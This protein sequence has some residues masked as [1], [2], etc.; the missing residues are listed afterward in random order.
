M[1]LI[2][3]MTLIMVMLLVTSLQPR[4]FFVLKWVVSGGRWQAQ[5]RWQMMVCR[6]ISKS[7]VAQWTSL[8]LLRISELLL[9]LLLLS[10]IF[11][12][13]IFIVPI[14]FH[15][16]NVADNIMMIIVEIIMQSKSV[17]NVTIIN[18]SIFWKGRQCNLL[19]IWPHLRFCDLI[20]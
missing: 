5:V 1:I 3:I 17:Q 10:L 16:Y 8:A 13:I 4:T 11:Y 19:A 15:H 20:V 14:V 6:S 7:I 18:E 12:L 9:L 2:T